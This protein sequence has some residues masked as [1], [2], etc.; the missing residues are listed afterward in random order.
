MAPSLPSEL[1]THRQEITM[2]THHST[3][4]FDVALA[5]QPLSDVAA[6]AGLGRMSLDKR[7]H[8]AL[9]AWA[10]AAGAQWI[11]LGVVDGNTRGERFW[12]RQGYVET[13]LRPGMT[14][15]SKVN[16]VR[17]LF[18]PLAGGTRADYLALVVRDRPET[19]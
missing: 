19:A 18:K 3:G 2:S 12:R 16:T 11:R 9:E 10:R 14:M 15:G 8:G 13:R 17:V 7:F 1:R 5:P 6:P 4:P